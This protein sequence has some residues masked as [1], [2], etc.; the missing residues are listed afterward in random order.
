MA[1]S[2]RMTIRCPRCGHK[3]ELTVPTVQCVLV[4]D[5]AGC[6]AELRRARVSCSVFCFHADDPISPTDVASTQ[7]RS[8][9][10]AGAA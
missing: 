7:V 8:P 1:T 10:A 6:G 3:S 9:G 2:V 5:C 4:H